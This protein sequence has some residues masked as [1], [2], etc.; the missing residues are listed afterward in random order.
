MTA[1]VFEFG[2]GKIQR[3][4]AENIVVALE[5]LTERARKGEIL[6]LGVCTV[7]EGSVLG[8]L[9]CVNGEWAA[10]IAARS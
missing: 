9:T 4:P 3:T 5:E 10:L 6:A 2:G 7:E 1:E 8:G